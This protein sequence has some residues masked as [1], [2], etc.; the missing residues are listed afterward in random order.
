M[1]HKQLP[2]RRLV[3]SLVLQKLPNT[4]L[5]GVIVEDW[6]AKIIWAKEDN[7]VFKRSAKQKYSHITI[8]TLIIFPNVLC[9]IFCKFYHFKKLIDELK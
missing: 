2:C 3:N 4:I 1:K 5:Q 7:R 9:N 6:K 8:T